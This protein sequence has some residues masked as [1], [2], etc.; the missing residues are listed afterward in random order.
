MIKKK[1]KTRK[2]PKKIQWMGLREYSRHRGVHLKT[3]QVAIA[4]GKIEV[5]IKSGAKKIDPKKADKSWDEKVVQPDP[6]KNPTLVDSRKAAL[7]MQT[8]LK[9]LEF[10]KKMGDLVDGFDV[11]KKATK[12]AM[13]LR[14]AFLRIPG[15]IA[16][17]LAVETDPNAVEKMLTKEIRATLGEYCYSRLGINPDK[18]QV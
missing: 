16:A 11:Q 2:K 7:D 1:K 13:G 6:D 3:V 14:D 4:E 17:E 15:K 8:K 5:E 18:K 9:E 12:I 10:K